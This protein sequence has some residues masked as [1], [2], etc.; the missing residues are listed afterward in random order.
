M[1]LSNILF[2]VGMAILC[3]ALRSC[4]HPLL[5]RTGTLGIFVTSFLAGWLLG[6]EI[7]LG[8][9]FAA[10]WLFLPWV[11][12]LTRIRTLRLP[13]E[14]N[15]R[16]SAPP[17]SYSFPGLEDL[18][19]EVEENGF[20][21][22]EDASWEHDG[23]KHFYRL[24]YHSSLHLQAAICLVEQNDFGFFYISLTSRSSDSDSQ[25]MTWN[26][27]FSYGMKLPPSWKVQRLQGEILFSE[28]VA[29]HREFLL[30][31]GL[32]PEGMASQCTQTMCEEI[33]RS[34][35]QQIN[36][37]IEAGLLLRDPDNFIRYSVRGMFF[38][39]FQFLRDLVRLS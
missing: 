34:V 18:T 16:P 36:H 39:W 9:A 5:H 2:V 12:I 3:W 31:K 35:E 14:R 25:F 22:V 17:S 10:S 21:Y 37:N 29:T 27:P 7:W 38:L 28:M 24:F 15:L 20:E 11:E 8:V 32:T 33:R 26:Y 6:G 30:G 13:A 4:H 19:E 1:L 23:L